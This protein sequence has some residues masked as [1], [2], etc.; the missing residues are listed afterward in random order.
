MQ[1]FYTSMSPFSRKVRV[2]IQEKSLQDRVE[3]ILC[4]PF[5]EV[6][7]LQQVNPLGK[8]PALKLLDESSLY[9][10]SVICEYLDSLR[11]D[12]QLI[13]TQGKERFQ[14]LRLQAVGDGIMDAT[15]A[16][17]TETRRTDAERSGEWL[18]RWQLAIDRSL[19]LLESDVRDF[20]KQID[21]GQIAIACALGQL[22]FRIPEWNWRENHSQLTTWF[23]EFNHRD[24][25]QS[26]MPVL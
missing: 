13:P 8:V 25:I 17:V 11:P 3:L 5:A 4:S 20:P 15:F 10:S 2:C 1:L 23:E 21:L 6:S 19:D 7:Q 12:P 26:T 16:T 14:V 18:K 22:D 24:S 9:D